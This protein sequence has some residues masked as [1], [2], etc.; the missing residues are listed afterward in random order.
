MKSMVKV[1]DEAVACLATAN[2]PTLLQDMRPDS[3]HNLCRCTWGGLPTRGIKA[4]ILQ[5]QHELGLAA[6]QVE[7]N[8][9]RG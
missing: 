6:H 1:V 5:A 4:P 8:I 7:H 3:L 2:H 9:A